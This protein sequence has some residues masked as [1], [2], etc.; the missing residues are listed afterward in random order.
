MLR[1]LQRIKV[2]A[3]FGAF[4][5][6]ATSFFFISYTDL[7]VIII[8]NSSLLVVFTI[9]VILHGVILPD[10]DVKRD[11]KTVKAHHILSSLAMIFAREKVSSSNLLNDDLEVKIF[12][13]SW[14]PPPYR[15]GAG[16]CDYAC[17]HCTSLA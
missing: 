7:N 3:A 1:G 15:G 13:R 2:I 10:R 11:E 4:L 8:V 6:A 14:N 17:Q 16:A 5:C 9:A 12:A